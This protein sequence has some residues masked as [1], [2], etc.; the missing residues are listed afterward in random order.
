MK[1]SILIAALWCIVAIPMGAQEADTTAERILGNRL[2]F[3]GAAALNFSNAETQ[4]WQVEPANFPLYERWI[5]DSLRFSDGSTCFTFVAGGIVGLP[6]DETWQFT[7]RLG[8]NWMAASSALDQPTGQDSLLK[9]SWSASLLYLELAPGIEAH[10]LIA[11]VPVYFLGGLELGIPM[12]NSREQVTDLYVNDQYL[13]QQITTGPAE[14]SET[15]L[16][17]ALMLG[18]GYTIPLGQDMWLQPE[19]S[20]RLP[21]TSVSSDDAHSPWKIGQLRLGVNL[22]FDLGGVEEPPPP[23]PPALGARI[24]RVTARDRS[25]REYDVTSLNVEDVAYT[26]MFPLAPYVFYPESGDTPARD[27][28]AT[29]EGEEGGF[30]I[31][32]LELDAIEVN[33]NLLNIVGSRMVGAPQSTLTI[34]GSTDGKSETGVPELGN[35]RALWAKDYLVNRFGIQPNRIAVNSRPLPSR[36]S[37]QNDPDGIIENRRIELSSN[38]PNILAPLTITADNQRIATP[39]L[40][41]FHTSLENGDSVKD[42]DM[43]VMQAGRELRTMSGDGDPN[44]VTWQIKPNELSTAQVPVDYELT[45]RTNDGRKASAVGTVPV[46]YLSSVQKRTENLPD[47]TV[48]K[49]SL[50]LFDFDAATLNEDNIR[51]LDESVLPS[52]K[53]NSKVSIIG[54]SDR[55]GGDDYNKKLSTER[56]STVSRYLSEKAPDAQFNTL[57]LGES[58]EIFPNSNPIGRQLSRTVQ[59]IV[60]TPRR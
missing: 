40:I 17:A 5:N 2:G 49:Y 16:R 53:S 43:R 39:D 58:T 34:T 6:I 48:D 50:I 52:I 37:A 21:L 35:R 47:R 32:N 18:A 3:Y 30:S 24:D 22:T 28:Q 1:S 10:D 12:S 51:I 14:V 42:W 11:D 4:A 55:I 13:G 56:A 23:P 59:V 9:H 38:V 20:Y 33:R 15:S 19:I 44:K 41:T 57:G 27:M 45:V 31:D 60:E 29:A 36:P 26:E 8:I 25:G 54:Y 46:D 7:G